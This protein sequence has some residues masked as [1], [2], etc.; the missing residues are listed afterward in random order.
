MIQLKD[1]IHFYI[2][3]R[4]LVDGD[5]YGR[6]IGGDFIPND[7]NQIY[8]TILID[9]EDEDSLNVPYNDDYGDD[10]R[11]RPL[12]KRLP[13]MSNKDIEELIGWEKIK[14]LYVNVSY[15]KIPTGIKINYSVITEYEGPYPQSHTIS[16]FMF[17]PKDIAFLTAKGYDIFQLIPNN[18]AID[19]KTLN[20]RD[21]NNS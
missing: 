18:E 10:L 6:L 11:I 3:S 4:V 19:I 20:Q 21:E 13:D 7:C 15:D 17:A 12:L 5:K 2:G 1:V 16:F 14:E 8:Y 9:G